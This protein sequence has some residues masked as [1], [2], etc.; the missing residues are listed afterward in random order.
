MTQLSDFKWYVVETK[1]REEQKAAIDIG[2]RGYQPLFLHTTDWRGDGPE[3]SRLVKRSWLPR[4]IFAGL[5]PQHFVGGVPVLRPVAEARGVSSII[6]PLPVPLRAMELL[7]GNAEFPSGLVWTRKTAHHFAGRP[8]HLVKLSDKSPY[9][10]FLAAITNIDL[11]GQIVVEIETF[12]RKVPTHIG[13][14]DVDELFDRNG[15]PIQKCEV[16]GS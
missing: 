14:E 1:P 6:S 2:K 11:R 3:L 8:G 13:L 4:Y 15:E 5:G 7:L 9:H 12:G 16:G 10:G